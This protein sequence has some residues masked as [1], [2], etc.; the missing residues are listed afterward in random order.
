MQIITDNPS[1]AQAKYALEVALLQAVE[2]KFSNPDLGLALPLTYPAQ[3]EFSVQWGKLI[4]TWWTEQATQS[5]RIV[6]Y[7]VIQDEIRLRATQSFGRNLTT[8]IL[9]KAMPSLTKAL[10]PN[11]LTAQPF[12]E[13]LR[14]LLQ[15][16]FQEVQIKILP[17][18]NPSSREQ[19]RFVRLRLQQKHAA[20]GI[21][22]VNE[23]ESAATI[24]EIVAV[25]LRW[26]AQLN[27]ATKPE[28]QVQHFLFC[29]PQGQAQ[30]VL[31]RLSLLKPNPFGARLECAEINL[32]EATL[33][34]RTLATQT[35]L[36]NQHF[37]E[38]RW[39]E[40][41]TSE[42]PW[43]AR[44]LA[45]APDLIELRSRPQGG[46]SYCLH[47]LEFARHSNPRQITLHFGVAG[48]PE[49]GWPE[50]APLARS[51]QLTEKTFPQLATLVQ[52]I[53][54][55]RQAKPPAPRHPLYRLRAEAWLEALLRRNIRALDVTLNER[56][57][58][59]Q[60]PAWQADERS[61]LDLLTINHENRLVVIEIKARE[62][63]HLPFQG[64]DYWLRVEQARLRGELQHRGLFPGQILA[65]Q[66]P[67]LYLVAPRLR[68]HRA[69]ALLAHCFSPQ[70]E[71]YRIGINGN[72][73][74][75]IQVQ[76]HERFNTSLAT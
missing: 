23:T 37:R 15:Q 33:S 26:L 8:L 27:Q 19:P 32:R 64:L 67:L 20:W 69:F 29:V 38:L 7:Q 62:D 14:S 12:A 10:T 4:F 25:G 2:W 1:A 63:L 36:L 75:G 53:R 16:H 71:V 21:I 59:S 58:Y 55:Y 57:V 30:T 65:A 34:W 48:W 11:L 70:I 17:S 40:P 47:G 51:T 18:G 66:P 43:H 46:T 52:E 72:W 44:I 41:P 6:G 39:P 76:T 45:L 5:W 28:K 42:N 50:N 56:F 13:Q 54:A 3:F 24:N 68:F 35:E 9:R 61:V 60:I 49:N 31:E 22:A 73:R 74:A